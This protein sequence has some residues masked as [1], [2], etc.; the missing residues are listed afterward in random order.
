MNAKVL[1]ITAPKGGA[2]KT[3]T[4]LMLAE[5]LTR[6][7]KQV[8][9]IDL[10]QQRNA[11]NLY[12]VV[13]EDQVT[14]YDLLTDPSVDAAEGI[15]HRSYSDIIAGDALI[16]NAEAEMVSLMC[17]ETML[18]DALEP[19][20]SLYDYII[21]DCPPSLGIVTTNALI[22]ADQ[23]I[24]PVI[25]DGYSTED[26]DRFKELIDTVKCNKRLNPSLSIGGILLT[27][28]YA[29]ERISKS[30]DEQLQGLAEKY[31]TKAYKARIRRC[32]K[33][34]EAAQYHVSLFDH[35]PKCT[36]VQDYKCFVKEILMEENDGE[37]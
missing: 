5:G 15:Q 1:A 7:G 33:T 19:L 24:V 4:S 13:V 10:D 17:K 23:V 18:T 2:S 21:L 31:G 32:V 26:L 36:T 35:A 12:D 8:L 37:I 29:P 22:A 3:T 14:V 20:R 28:F 30:Y 34:R 6:E 16:T 25:P 9:L 11:S 27:Q